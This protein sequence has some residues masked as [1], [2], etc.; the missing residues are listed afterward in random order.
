MKSF[1]EESRQSVAVIIPTRNRPNELSSVLECLAEQSLQPVVVIVVDSSDSRFSEEFRPKLQNYI[2]I[3][4]TSR[5]AAMQR[6]IGMD[7][8][9]DN[10]K[11]F[12]FIAFVD[13]DVLLPTHYLEILV[14]NLIEDSELA[15]VSGIAGLE[16]YYK[17]KKIITNLIGITGIQGRITK[18]CVNIPVKPGQGLVKSADWLIGCS[19]WRYSD[20]SNIFFEKDFEG[21]SIFEDVIFS[22]R[23]KHLRQKKLC[24]NSDLIFDHLISPI[25][26]ENYRSQY[27]NWVI[28]RSRFQ[29]IFPT[30]FPRN[31][32]ILHSIVLVVGFLLSPILQKR[33]RHSA[34][35][36]LD[37][38][39]FIL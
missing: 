14:D 22:H 33:R 4:T 11:N 38:L 27:R 20:I 21:N 30:S 19:L 2:Y 31:R 18:A 17:S 23:V 12:Q 39:R 3:H 32:L 29:S 6:N 1:V 24:V 34:L 13:D 35:G 26:R 16:N 8:I 15:G 5:S 25:E 10:E 36:I 9:W 37:A 7:W 28:N